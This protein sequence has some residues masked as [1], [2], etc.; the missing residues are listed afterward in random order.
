MRHTLLTFTLFSTLFITIPE[1]G[2]TE[3]VVE[4]GAN[5]AAV[6]VTIAAAGH[7]FAAAAI[8]GAAV[9][10][11]TFYGVGRGGKRLYCEKRCE[12]SEDDVIDALDGYFFKHAHKNSWE[13]GQ[14]IAED[15][16]KNL[17]KGATRS[18]LAKAGKILSCATACSNASTRKHNCKIFSRIKSKKLVKFLGH[19]L[20][21]T[22]S[23][24]FSQ[25]T[26]DVPYHESKLYKFHTSKKFG[27]KGKTAAESCLSNVGAAD[28]TQLDENLGILKH[29]H[30][31][32]MR[33]TESEHNMAKC[34]KSINLHELMAY[35]KKYMEMN[36]VAM[37]H[38][39]HPPRSV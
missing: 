6:A 15:Y 14:E 20:A 33:F 17:S 8:A 2:H 18:P 34:L 35:L 32:K 11:L 4:T 24:G 16:K 25:E 21:S 39:T 36:G 9:A 7:P 5:R 38:A 22:E 28:K 3:G 10:A 30:H 31:E 1:Y 13:L 23:G 29:I 26:K 19:L 27:F 12:R 37:A